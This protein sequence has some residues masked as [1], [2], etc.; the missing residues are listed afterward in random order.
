MLVADFQ[1][2]FLMVFPFR[3]ALVLGPR[4]EKRTELH[5]PTNLASC[6]CEPLSTPNQLSTPKPTPIPAF[7][8]PPL[9][10]PPKTSSSRV[11]LPPASGPARSSGRCGSA[12]SASRSGAARTRSAGARRTSPSPSRG[13]SPLGEKPHGLRRGPEGFREIQ[14]TY[15]LYMYVKCICICVYVFIY[16][17]MNGYAVWLS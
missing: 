6:L 3:H 11:R 15:N 1:A 4:H 5:K 17:Y 8:K 10:L 2:S 13:T 7:P 9:P 12:R 16:I 14:H